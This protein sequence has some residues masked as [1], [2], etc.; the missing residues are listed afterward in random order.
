MLNITR[1]NLL[2]V[3]LAV[4]SFRISFA[5]SEDALDASI[6]Q[7]GSEETEVSEEAA[8]ETTAPLLSTEPER[9]ESVP[10]IKED[11]I[12]ELSNRKLDTNGQKPSEEIEDAGQTNLT[13]GNGIAE[14]GSSILENGTAASKPRWNCSLMS[15]FDNDEEPRV[16]I[17]KNDTQLASIISNSNG[18]QSCFL[19]YF[20]VN[21]CEFCAEFSV[22]INTIGR[23]FHGL[24]VIGV[25]AYTLSSIAGK[26]GITGVP[27]LL[28]FYD[29]RP[30]AKFN[31][32]RTLQGLEEFITNST[33]ITANRS[34]ETHDED[35]SG[36]LPT[37]IKTHGDIYLMLSA[38]SIALIFVINLCLTEQVSN[39][40]LS[41]INRFKEWAIH[42]KT[43]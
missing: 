17:L 37:K 3:F 7:A 21:W 10:A 4:L 24:P 32:S 27:S 19:L 41:N 23:I 40:C 28:L 5:N 43:D 1:N 12:E 42:Q 26:Y 20:Y 9:H 18:N 36:P 22:E 15:L 39:F 30:V 29:G 38:L 16:F 35:F 31:R 34:L 11:Q 14:N 33:G 6:S 8:Q 2:A 13:S 25:D